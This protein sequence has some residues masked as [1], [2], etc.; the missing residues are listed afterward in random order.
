MDRFV[1]RIGGSPTPSKTDGNS[2]GSHRPYGQVEDAFYR[3]RGLEKK[4]RL[5]AS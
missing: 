3:P 5:E 2:S 1:S 4:D